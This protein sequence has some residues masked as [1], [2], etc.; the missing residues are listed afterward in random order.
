[1]AGQHLHDA[2]D[3]TVPADDRVELLLACLLREVAAELVEDERAGRRF[4]A[5]A[6]GSGARL[7][8]LAAGT[9]VA[10]WELDD[11]LAHARQIGAELHEHLRGDA[12]AL[13]DQPEEDVFGADVVVTE[14]QRFAQ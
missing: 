12:L 5:A 3:L 7:L 1:A 10:R 9:A 2:L 6:A 4:L 8:R 13:A 14:L 11:L